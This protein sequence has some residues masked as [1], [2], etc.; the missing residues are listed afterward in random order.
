VSYR[1]AGATQ[2][3][4]SLAIVKKIDL[5]KRTQD[6]PQIENWR[7]EIAGRGYQ[8]INKAT[9]APHGDIHMS[10]DVAKSVL[11]SMVPKAAA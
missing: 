3:G 2:S 8:V 1:V 7:I 4:A 6:L 5:E 9:H 10:L 11:F